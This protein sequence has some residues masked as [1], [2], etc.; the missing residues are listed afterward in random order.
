MKKYIVSMCLSFLMITGIAKAEVPNPLNVGI[1]STESS[2][3]L[4]KNWDTFLNDLAAYLKVEVKPFLQ[5]IILELL[6]EC[7]LE[8]FTSRGLGI[9]L[10]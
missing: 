10:R 2:T 4:K 5:L 9:N 1:I 8:R 6:R 7:G 3:I